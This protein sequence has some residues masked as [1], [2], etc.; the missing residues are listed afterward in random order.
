MTAVVTASLTRDARDF[1]PVLAHLWRSSDESGCSL[2]GLPNTVEIANG[3]RP[4]NRTNYLYDNLGRLAGIQAPGAAG[5]ENDIVFGYD[6]GGR[7][8]ERRYSNGLTTR[9]SYHA[10][11]SVKQVQNL[12][13]SGTVISQ[14]DYTYDLYGNRLTHDETGTANDYTYVYDELNRLVSAA[15]SA[16][17]ETFAYD[18]LNNLKSRTAGGVTT[19]Y[20]PTTTTPPTS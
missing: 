2:A 19:T 5:A 7:R 18:P 10:D 4:R 8:T 6:A 17:T 1:G 13:A 14:H 3:D 12:R 20:N 16:G 9:Y 15:N 11:N